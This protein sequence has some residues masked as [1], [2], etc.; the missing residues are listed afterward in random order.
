MIDHIK[1]KFG[2]GRTA[3]PLEFDTTP[4]TVF[5]GPNYS[6]KSKIIA[7]I[8]HRCFQGT[9]APEVVLENLRF[10]TP[11]PT[12]IDEMVERVRSP[13]RP[14]ETVSP[15]NLMVGRNHRRQLIEAGL[16]ASL[17]APN[18]ASRTSTFVQGY[19]AHQVLMLN[20]QNRIGL[21]N[22]QSGGDLQLAGA[23]SFH[24]LFRDDDKRKRLSEIVFRAFGMHLVVDPT[25]LGQLRLRFSRVPASPQLERSLSEEAIQF[26]RDATHI[27]ETSDGAKA[28]VGILAEIIAGEPE[29]LLIDEPEAFLHPGLSYALGREVAQTVAQTNKK[30]FVSTHSSHFLMG[31]VQAG[32]PINVVRLTYREGVATARLL[33]SVD[34]VRMMRNPL[35]RS[36]GVIS[37]LFFESAVVTEA[38]PD[39]V[40]YQEI[41]DRLTR[42][43]RGSQNC[44]FL[45]A[46]NKQTIPTIM[47]PLRRLGIPTAAIYDI[48]VVKEGRGTATSYFNSAGVPTMSQQPLTTA[49][50][51]IL[52]A[53]ES[54]GQNFKRDGG[55][56][57]L[58]GEERQAA[59]DYLEQ[60]AAYGMFV[61]PQGELENW[62]SGLCVQ[63]HGP[64]W[65]IPIFERMGEDPSAGNYVHPAHDDV[66]AFMDR[67]AEWLGNPMRKGIPN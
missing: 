10:R 62:L 3:P 36:T 7:E 52:K 54:T 60:L 17:A 26:H 37:A 64:T 6:G 55:I 12:Q 48:D 57:L 23:G 40:F 1:L 41:N 31:C 47:Y 15:G 35:L 2:S 24:V 29:I 39:R 19:L 18:E 59:D 63:G 9:A 21:I 51:N 50:A 22:D 32:V 56:N 8:H 25:A 42:I 30:I 45:N 28:F 46:Q 16:R 49:R 53:L 66:W 4:I 65:L 5:V 27:M 14:G 58:V 67:I 20:G 38:D 61:V 34:L 43:G 44:I 33:P 11:D 13:A